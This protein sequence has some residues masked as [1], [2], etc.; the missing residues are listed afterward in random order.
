M[1]IQEILAEFKRQ[2]NATNLYIA[3]KIGVT[4]ST[5]SRWCR[6]QIKHVAPSTMERLS[7]LLGTDVQALTQ[8]IEFQL[9]KPVLGTVK[10]GYGLLAEE[11]LDGY[12]SVSQEDFDRGDY[13]LR[14]TGDSMEG[15][16]ILDGD[17]LYVKPATTFPPAPLPLCSSAMKRPRSRN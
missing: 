11:N 3:Q 13:F 10:A 4:P 1:K 5:V 6:G 9:E 14:V 15:A 17:L 16:H 12:M 8:A 2:N 7:E